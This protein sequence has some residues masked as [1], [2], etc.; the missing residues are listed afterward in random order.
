ML[1]TLGS[2]PLAL[3]PILGRA[4]PFQSPPGDP[5]IAARLKKFLGETDARPEYGWFNFED[6]LYHDNKFPAEMETHPDVW[7]FGRQR[8][9]VF[10][11]A[12]EWRR[13]EKDGTILCYCP[14]GELMLTGEKQVSSWHSAPPNSLEHVGAHTRFV[15]RSGRQRDSGVL[16][17][18]QF[19]LG[20]NPAVELEVTEADAEWQ[21]CVS[22]KGR[23]G[24][25][26]LASPWQRGP[27]KL[28]FDLEKELRKRGYEFQYPELHFAIG[29]WTPRPADSAQVKFRLRMPG[30]AAVV[31]GLPVIRTTERAGKEGV[32]LTAAVL[33]GKGELLG[34]GRARVV[35]TI[36]GKK[37]PLTEDVGAWKGVLRDLPVGDHEVV[38]TAE[39]EIKANAKSVVRVTDGRFFKYDKAS[40]WVTKDGK[41]VGPLSG[42]YQGTFFFRDAGLPSERLVQG[43]KEWDAW[44]RTK[45]PGEHMHYWEAVTPRELDERFAFLAKNGFDLLTLHSHWGLWER[46]DAG[47]RIAPHAAEQLAM[48]LRTAGR[49]GLAHVQALSSGPYGVPESATGYGDTIP[50][51]RY[52]EEG[53]K[54]ENWSKP[55]NKFDD[56]FYQYTSDFVE[57]FRDETALFAM[58]PSGEGDS[59]APERA[60]HIFRQ[61]RDQDTNHLIL[62]ESIDTLKELPEKVCAPDPQ[63][64]LGGRTYPIATSE[65]L[66][67]F[68]IGVEFKL[69]RTVNNIYMAEGSWP[70]MPSYTRMHY[71][72]I[73][74][75]RGSRI[76]WTGMPMYRIRLRDTFYLGLVHLLPVMNTWDEEM[77]ED[78]HLL[79]KQ[80]RSQ[81]NW[82]Q[83]FLD[84]QVALF[85]DDACAA[86]AN[87]ARQNV[88]QYEKAFVR[89]PLA[90]R[91]YTT[92]E[93]PP[94]TLIAL[95]GRQPFA[96]PKFRSEGGTLPDEL[97]QTMP[98]V[99]SEPYCSSYTQTEDKQTLLAYFYN[100]AEHTKEYQWLGGSY[101]RVPKP[102]PFRIKVQNLP[103]ANLRYRLYDLNEK[104]AVRE[105]LGKQPPDW[106]LGMT[107]HDYFLLVTPK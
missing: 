24:A 77:T 21:F 16:P 56:L 41:P 86:V 63:D 72:V 87:P 84:P 40:R 81:V 88:A 43:Q 37:V 27:G 103:S 66:P 49:H 61:V 65:I 45:A 22:I 19:H 32:P 71:E 34:A 58:T 98:L 59:R 62:A 48:Y 104:K 52:L 55:G 70:P 46:L 69:Y 30:R 20:Q 64:M 47:G 76:C 53:F 82:T 2:A 5:E 36:A 28:T 17:A 1:G 25:P 89:I 90:Y 4:N 93:P 75:F 95:D 68:D 94:G 99:I 97:K 31:A 91:M 10:N 7:V 73:K 54:A 11:R 18:F 96:E 74:D 29:L 42:S 6:V 78:E 106:S 23:G 92:P 102:A 12:M 14:T 57:L 35:A 79:F 9:W 51:S 15:K 39:G 38:I 80:I 13:D 44:D 26:M 67:E 60:R 8:I 101:H 107:D 100:T 83:R 85:V 50:Y 33:G 105:A 3:G